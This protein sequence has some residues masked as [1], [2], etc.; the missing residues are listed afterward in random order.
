MQLK[1]KGI[2]SRERERERNAPVLK[3]D[4][5]LK[6]SM[7]ERMGGGRKILKRKQEK[8][9]KKE[10]ESRKRKERR[11][12]RKMKEERGREEKRR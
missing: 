2:A 8:D 4:I 10:R 9:R 11:E 3:V 1:E 6:Q 5:S 7:G 12:S